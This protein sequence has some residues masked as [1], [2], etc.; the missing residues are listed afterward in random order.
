MKIKTKKILA[1]ILFLY[2]IPLFIVTLSAYAILTFIVETAVRSGEVD[3]LMAVGQVFNVI[4]GILGLLAIIGVIFGIPAGSI[5][6][7]FARKQEKQMLTPG[8]I[9][10]DQK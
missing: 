4:L 6:Y 3:G 8:A 9:E 1:F 5:L 10:P 2:P 7:F